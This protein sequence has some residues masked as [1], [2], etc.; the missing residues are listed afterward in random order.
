[1]NVRTFKGFGECALFLQKGAAT[2]IPITELAVGATAEILMRETRKGFGDHALA[3]LTQTTQDERTALGYTADDPLLRDGALLRDSVE[4]EVGPGWAGVGS[5]EPVMGYSELG[6]Y[7]HWSQS[8]T[9]PRP[10]FFIALQ[11][12][13]A[14]IMRVLEALAQAVLGFGPITAITHAA[15]ASSQPSL[16]GLHTPSASY[17]IEVK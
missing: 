9:P 8:V 7:N 13:A 1:M 15:A 10:V 6:A 5:S 16:P 14:P 3:E 4:Q 11:M 2:V 12:A 17:N